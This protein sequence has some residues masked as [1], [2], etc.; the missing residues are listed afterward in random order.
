MEK[1]T[2]TLVG[3]L[4]DIVNAI[5]LART[6][7]RFLSDEKNVLE[8]IWSVDGVERAEAQI[9]IMPDKP[10]N[11]DELAIFTSE[12]PSLTITESFDDVV[13]LLTSGGV[14]EQVV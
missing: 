10:I 6:E 5:D 1:I 13:Q 2:Y 14:K 11:S 12:F 8:L 7:G 9:S 3:T 4:A